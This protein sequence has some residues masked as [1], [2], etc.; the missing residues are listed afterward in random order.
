MNPQRR[1]AVADRLRYFSR[2]ILCRLLRVS[3]W[4]ASGF[5]RHP[6]RA[7]IVEHIRTTRPE[8][9]LEIGSGFGDIICSLPARIRWASD[10][11]TR[12]L[13]GARLCH[14]TDWLAGRIHFLPLTLGE[15]PGRQF[16]VVICVNFIHGIPPHVLRGHFVRLLTQTIA[17]GGCLIFD[18]V[19]DPSY[20]FRHDPGFLLQGTRVRRRVIE[21]FPYG[22]SIVVAQRGFEESPCPSR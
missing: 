12:V 10:R 11:S 1:R 14:L 18:V 4:H 20:R 19:G 15:D 16:D 7:A 8:S 13:A 3:T 2:R 6:Y 22:R 21:G 5:A 17:P 9:V